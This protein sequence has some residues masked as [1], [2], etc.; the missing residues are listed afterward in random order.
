MKYPIILFFCILIAGLIACKK[1]DKNKIDCENLHTGLL[2]YNTDMVNNELANT[3]EDL[4]PVITDDDIFGHKN[5]FAILLDLLNEC[6]NISAELLCYTCIETLPVQSEIEL[7]I[8][9]S[10]GSI[11]RIIDIITADNDN[12][13][14]N[15]IHK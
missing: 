14:F 10:G 6:P 12:I 11:T 8:D 1:A 3:L 15:R 4:E 5:N 9:A 13:S 2:D 7:T